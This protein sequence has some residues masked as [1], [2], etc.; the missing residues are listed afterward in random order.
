MRIFFN[1]VGNGCKVTVSEGYLEGFCGD[2][3]STNLR[4]LTGVSFYFDDRFV[5][6]DVRVRDGTLDQWKGDDLKTLALQA[7]SFAMDRRPA[8]TSGMHRAV[9]PAALAGGSQVD[10]K[11]ASVP[12]PV[13]RP[14]YLTAGE[15]WQPGRYVIVRKKAVGA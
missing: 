7:R 9:E 12:P 13:V 11:P 3:A 15:R 8:R 2:R 6:L 5:L 14:A 1:P 10:A 4:G